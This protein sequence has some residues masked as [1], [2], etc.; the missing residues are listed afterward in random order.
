MNMTASAYP[1]PSGS[2]RAIRDAAAM[3]RAEQLGHKKANRHKRNDFLAAL[4]LVGAV[5]SAT[6]APPLL[7]KEA[8]TSTA[9]KVAC[10]EAGQRLAPWFRAEAERKA[11]VG[12]GSVGIHAFHPCW[13]VLHAS[14]GPLCA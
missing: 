9:Q 8:A 3:R 12:L 2:H 11:L 1:A 7:S 5:F 6:T 14:D 13:A 4:V 10:V